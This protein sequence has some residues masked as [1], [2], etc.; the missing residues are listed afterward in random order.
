MTYSRDECSIWFVDVLLCEITCRDLRFLMCDY[1]WQMQFLWTIVVDVFANIY[2][3]IVL[4]VTILVENCIFWTFPADVLFKNVLLRSFFLRYLCKPFLLVYL[5]VCHCAF[6]C[7]CTRATWLIR[8][9]ETP[10]YVVA[11]VRHD[12]SE[13]VT[14][15]RLCFHASWFYRVAFYASSP[16]ISGSFAKRDL[17]LHRMP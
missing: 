11:H 17:Q 6:M 15:L 13:H 16:I 2:I 1:F 14:F 7:T 3:Y 10:L 12:F 4:D 5:N 9:R 8:T